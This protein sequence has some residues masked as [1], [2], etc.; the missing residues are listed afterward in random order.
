M[1]FGLSAETLVDIVGSSYGFVG[2]GSRRGF[3]ALLT[4]C[5]RYRSNSSAMAPIFFPLFFFFCNTAGVWLPGVL[6]LPLTWWLVSP[7]L[8]NGLCGFF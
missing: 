5:A 4:F 6:N 2:P 8:P 3:A 1:K 7:V